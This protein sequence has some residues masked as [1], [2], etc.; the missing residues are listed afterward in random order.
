M[1]G[2]KL[3]PF[4]CKHGDISLQLCIELLFATVANR[5]IGKGCVFYTTY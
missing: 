4:V 1:D 2:Q 5:P 3:L